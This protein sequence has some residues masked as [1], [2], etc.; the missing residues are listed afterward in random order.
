VS[1]DA[2]DKIKEFFKWK[3]ALHG[4]TFCAAGNDISMNISLRGIH[5]VDPR[6]T[7]HH[8]RIN[9]NRFLPVNLVPA[10]LNIARL[11]AAIRAGQLRNEFKFRKGEMKIPIATRRV[12]VDEFPDGVKA[13]RLLTC[14]AGFSTVPKSSKGDSTNLSTN[15]ANATRAMPL[16]GKTHFNV[17]FD[18]NPKSKLFSDRDARPSPLCVSKQTT[19]AAGERVPIS[20]STD[21]LNFFFTTTATDKAGAIGLTFAYFQI[22]F[23]LN[24]R[25]ETDHSSYWKGWTGV[26]LQKG[27]IRTAVHT[28]FGRS[29]HLALH[30]Y[31]DCVP[32]ILLH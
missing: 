31:L 25:P 19:T 29:F 6:I 9:S 16:S 12:S 1:V 17:C 22:K 14:P 23:I 24:N 20:Q 30:G 26:R 28:C 4:V 21:S 5:A 11:F 18:H 32:P 2:R 3:I 13:A 15:T 8:Q 27:R 7:N 10:S